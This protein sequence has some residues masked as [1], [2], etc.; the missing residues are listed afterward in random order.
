MSV[1][2]IGL[3]IPKSYSV[4]SVS[5]MVTT[6]LVKALVK[7]FFNE[8][9]V[10]NKKKQLSVQLFSLH[11]HTNNQLHTQSFPHT[12]SIISLHAYWVFCLNDHIKVIAAFLLS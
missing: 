9:I 2:C 11:I 6:A 3:R 4:H 5:L 7:W 12:S 8:F 10:L 1:L